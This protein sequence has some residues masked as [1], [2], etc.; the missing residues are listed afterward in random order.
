[1]GS[2]KME[3]FVKESLCCSNGWSFG[4]LWRFD[5]RNSMLLR[6]EDAYY[7]EQMQ[8][9]AKDLLP[10]V[11]IL[12]EG[13][14]GQTAVSGKH[15]WISAESANL[16]VDSEISS[17]ISSGIKTICIIPLE[18]QGVIQLGSIQ[19]I[20]ERLEFVEQTKRLFSDMESA[21]SFDPMTSSLAC[22]ASDLNEWFASFC[23]G[24]ISPIRGGSCDQLAE[25][26]CT[27]SDITQSC[28]P[29]L[30][31][32]EVKI[33]PSFVDSSRASS[34][35]SNEG[36]ILTSLESQLGSEMEVCDLP[37][38]LSPKGNTPMSSF[39]NTGGLVELAQSIQQHVG[40]S[41][42]GQ[43]SLQQS[44]S[45][46]VTELKETETLCGFPDELKI[47]G[48]PTD[49]SSFFELMSCSS[50]VTNVTQ[51]VGVHGPR[52]GLLQD[53][54]LD[55]PFNQPTN[56]LQTCVSNDV[57][58]CKEQHKPA[59]FDVAQNDLFEVL[60]LRS[61]NDIQPLNPSTK[62]V[63]QKGLFSE[64]GLEE[65]LGGIRS[66]IVDDG[67]SPAKRIKMENS[68]YSV[69]Q[70]HLGNLVNVSC[71]ASSSTSMP[72][73]SLDKPKNLMFPKSPMAM[74]IDESYRSI[75][76]KVATTPGKAKKPEESVKGFKK[77]AR[78]GESSRPRPK[79]RQQIQD[80]LKEL[81]GIVPNAEKDSIDNLLARTI[82]HMRFLQ[83]VTKYADQLKQVDQPMISGQGNG[84][85]ATWA[86]EVGEE[87]VVCPVI[88][89]D[90]VP[91]GLML[92][93]ILC[94]DQGYFLEIAEAVRGLGLS[95]LKGVMKAQD[96][97]VWARFVVEASSSM[98]RTDV[99]W[100][101]VP[102]LPQAAISGVDQNLSSNVHHV[103]KNYQ[104]PGPAVCHIGLAEAT[105]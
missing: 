103:S 92:I 97:K 33:V 43:E 70:V 9:V 4:V 18:S 7:G 30:P 100:S 26:G 79:D 59:L 68:S 81:K 86:L 55:I 48:F 89:K 64:L 78:P 12:G 63:P 88:V 61:T 96:D 27:S 105:L 98:T 49:M 22:D 29:A 90:L 42:T 40:R 101:L 2:G 47:D 104:Q 46:S 20:P 6:V 93:E 28:D 102:L 80:R 23:N 66:S 54:L 73:C 82:K 58:V 87:T 53:V 74:L 31:L 76:S 65:L 50:Q 85:G 10:Q 69:N 21:H 11:H 95:I 1:M 52:S 37:W 41:R 51:P 16:Q 34:Q 67:A 32:E 60:G 71:S 19:K 14:V 91:P 35:W 39:Y 15:Q 83:S 3:S 45:S 57:D 84:N 8:I 99:L 13:I 72:S 17:L 62:V 56:S 36:S 25:F 77:R 44:T 94:K 38:T 5:Q 24:S 75:N